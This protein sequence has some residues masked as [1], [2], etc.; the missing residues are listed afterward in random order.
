[1]LIEQKKTM[2]IGRGALLA[3]AI[4]GVCSQA[5]AGAIASSNTTLSNF[6]IGFSSPNS[7]SFNGFSGGNASI[8]APPGPFGG[9]VSSAQVSGNGASTGTNT[10]VGT[11]FVNTPTSVSFSF[12]ADSNLVASLTPGGVVSAANLFMTISINDLL[13]NT[14]AFSWAPNGL[15]GGIVGGVETSDAF[16]LNYGITQFGSLGTT[17]FQSGN[18]LFAANSSLLNPGF[19]LMNISMSNSAFVSSGGL[20]V[21]SVPEPSVLWLV[22]VGFLGFLIARRRCWY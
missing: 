8:T 2:S 19:Y 18:G 14:S 13:A 20:P 6:A 22:G 16:D 10:W 21:A 5:E 9:A 3:F 4:M 12:S 15:V 7:I 1:M 17:S 11:F